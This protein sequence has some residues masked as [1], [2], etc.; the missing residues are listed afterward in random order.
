MRRKIP[1]PYQFDFLV[2]LS[3]LDCVNIAV[4]IV[5]CVRFWK[6]RVTPGEI[7]IS[8]YPGAFY[9]HIVEIKLKVDNQTSLCRKFSY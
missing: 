9:R 8:K 4:D 7:T 2:L 6:A 3:L 1:C 5:V